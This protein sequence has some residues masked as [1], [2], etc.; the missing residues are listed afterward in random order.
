[1]VSFAVQ[2]LISLIRSHWFIFVFIS[3]ALGD[4]P[5]KTFVS[6]M[7]ENVFPCPSR[8]SM[9]SCLMFKSL[10]HFEFIFVHGVRVYSSFIDLHSTVQ[11]SQHHLLRRLSF[12]NFIFFPPLSKI[13]YL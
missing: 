6:F 11:L 7:S 2:K 5:N 4:W 3:V 8:S 13:N 9:V 1:M 10:S 12:S